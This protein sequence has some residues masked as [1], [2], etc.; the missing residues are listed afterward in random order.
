MADAALKP[1]TI[2]EFFDWCPDDDRHWE[3]HDG[4]PIAM[5]PVN[6]EHVTLCGNFIMEI[7]QALRRRPGCRVGPSGG[8]R[9]PDRDDVYYEADVVVSCT[10][11]RAGQ[12][13]TPEPVLIVE[14]LSPSTGRDDRRR[15]LSDY[16]RI[17]S[18]REIVLADPRQVLLEIHRREAGDAWKTEVLQTPDS[19]LR[20]DS[21]GLETAVSAV[22]ENVLP[23][24]PDEE[25]T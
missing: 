3:L 13:E 15:K 18:V 7:G 24:S 17:P 11:F 23:A 8:I 2:E 10:P 12:K 25:D 20:L 5:A 1:M 22:Y 9:L 21:V 6:Q 14:V 4:H 19:V 16:R